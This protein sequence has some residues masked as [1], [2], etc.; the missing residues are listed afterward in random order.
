M[1][2]M[3]T[4]DNESRTDSEAT[5][6]DFDY[7]F[8]IMI[9]GESMVGKTSIINRY[10]NDK[11]G[12]RYLCTIGIDFQEKIIVKN[13][14]EIKLQ[15]WDTA[16][17]ERYRNVTKSYFQSSNGFILAYDISNKESFNQIKYWL[18]QIKTTSEESTKYILV[19]TKCD[20]DERE[21]PEEKGINLAQKLG[22]KFLET[23]A[24]LNININETFETLIDEILLNFKVEKRKS[25]MIS[26]KKMNKKNKK[27]CC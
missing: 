19:G 17:Q 24:K 27:N 9:L 22:I 23:S 4:N 6:N 2:N 21:V 5:V 25:L 16:G 3:T 20:L 12:E 1:S 26:S 18:D 13:D 8:K 15:I 11:F 10:V 7:R 14:K